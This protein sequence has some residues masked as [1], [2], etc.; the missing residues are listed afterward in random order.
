MARGRLDFWT[1]E[2]TVEVERWI[3]GRACTLLIRDMTDF[4]LAAGRSYDSLYS[5]VRRVRL[6]LRLC[7]KVGNKWKPKGH[8]MPDGQACFALPDLH[9]GLHVPSSL[10]ISPD[11]S[12]EVPEQPPTKAR[13]K[14]AGMA[15]TRP[16]PVRWT[17]GSGPTTAP[18]S[19]GA[20]HGLAMPSWGTR[21][22]R[23]PCTG[24]TPLVAFPLF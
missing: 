19:D 16:Q 22:G 24:Q 10:A 2:Q 8:V 11:V 20:T 6:R 1:H 9:S 7:E 23:T 17:H 15:V 3:L 18:A 14:D 12:E 13:R 5:K 21:K 4:A